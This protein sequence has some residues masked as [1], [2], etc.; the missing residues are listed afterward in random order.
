VLNGFSFDGPLFDLLDDFGKRFGLEFSVQDG[1]LEV[2]AEAPDD[3]RNADNR[4][5]VLISPQSGM[6][7]SPEKME[8]GRVRVH[9]LLNPAIALYR[10]IQIESRDYSGFFM[11]DNLR[12]GGDTHGSGSDWSVTIETKR[13]A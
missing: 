7:G 8:N 4:P 12:Y 5:P 9:S 13:P 10:R 2:Q 6:I 11:P 3:P 1:T